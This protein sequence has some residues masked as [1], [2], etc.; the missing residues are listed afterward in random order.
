VSH[1]RLRFADSGTFPQKMVCIV[2]MYKCVYICLYV[3]V[4]LYVYAD[5]S[6]S[7]EWFASNV[8]TYVCVCALSLSL[9]MC[10]CGGGGDGCVCMHVCVLEYLTHT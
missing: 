8:C 7:R 10:M 6:T 3:C 5:S 1:P 4:W 9:C 2:G